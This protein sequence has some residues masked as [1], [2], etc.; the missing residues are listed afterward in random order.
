MS[1]EPSLATHLKS[2]IKSKQALKNVIVVLSQLFVDIVHAL[3]YLKKPPT[4]H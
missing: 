3:D 2:Q 4:I 1:A